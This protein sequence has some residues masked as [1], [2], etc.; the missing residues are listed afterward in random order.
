MRQ[1][2][3]LILSTAKGS[4]NLRPEFGSD[5]FRY[6]DYPVNQAVPIMKRCIIEAIGI[7][8][9]RISIVSISHQIN[10]EQIIFFI[11]YK[12]VDQDL[13]DSIFYTPG[14]VITDT[15]GLILQAFYPPN[16]YGN[17]YIMSLVLNDVA[18][19]PVFPPSGYSTLSQLFAW[20]SENWANYGRWV[21]LVDRIVLYANAEYT[22]GSISISLITGTI[23]V[24]A[25]LPQLG[26]GETYGVN[27]SP[28]GDLPAPPPPSGLITPEALLMW[29]QA[30]WAGYGTWSIEAG[31][32]DVFGD[33]YS[34]EFGPDFNIG[35][36]AFNYYLVLNSTV[37]NTA[38]LNV[39]P[40]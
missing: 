3:S 34:I 19:S 32:I 25:L 24:Q 13:I 28:N 9:K 38:T 26:V 36:S 5:I 7:W 1:C 15:A 17:P 22:T 11:T 23:Q 37:L 16:P 27:F 2:I 33:F 12:P 39:I 18:A 29:V 40:V 8:E 4:D 6:I 30:N 35:G 20:V 10:N 14:G 31:A 21:Q